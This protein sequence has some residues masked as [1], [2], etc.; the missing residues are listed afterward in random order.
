[1][2][3]SYYIPMYDTHTYT[4]ILYIPTYMYMYVYICT[5]VPR[6]GG[7]ILSIYPMGGLIGGFKVNGTDSCLMLSDFEQN[8]QKSR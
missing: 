3:R 8:C 2:L 5:Y 7:L 6:G 4:S 1:M